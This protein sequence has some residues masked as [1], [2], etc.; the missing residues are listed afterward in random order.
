MQS[1]NIL[2][3]WD[4]DLEEAACGE[5]VLASSAGLQY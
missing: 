4:N 2:V 1:C 5:V 3:R